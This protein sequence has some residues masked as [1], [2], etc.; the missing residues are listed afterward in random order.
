MY[1]TDSYRVEDQ[2]LTGVS[3]DAAL[4]SADDG[5]FFDI[6]GDATL[7]GTPKR[8]ERFYPR[9]I[10]IEAFYIQFS[11]AFAAASTNTYT[12]QTGTVSGTQTT[13]AD[14]LILTITASA[15][16]MFQTTGSPQNIAESTFINVLFNSDDGTDPAESNTH[17]MRYR[18]G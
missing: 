16:G 10:V 17:G 11:V 5:K 3:F 1:L 9:G 8:R 7:N 2:Y 18:N 15:T 4:G 12:M 14:A 13:P 6:G